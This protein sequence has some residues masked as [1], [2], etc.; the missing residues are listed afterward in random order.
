MNRKSIIF[1]II[2]QAILWVACIHKEQPNSAK[3]QGYFRLEIPKPEYQKWDSLLPFSFDYSKHAVFSIEKNENKIYWLD[4]NYPQFNASL[5][6]SFL[7][8]ENNLRKLVVNEEKMLMFHV[9]SR[10]ADDIQYSDINDFEGKVYGQ[11]YELIGKGAATPLKFW[12]TDSTRYFVS[13]TLYFNFTPNN[14]SLQPV[15]NYLKTDILH[16]IETWKWK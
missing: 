1:L 14:D 16:M 11:M 4:L 8:V 13:A 3:P 7:P 6:M 9:E 15:I 10:K 5:K 12:V 2:L